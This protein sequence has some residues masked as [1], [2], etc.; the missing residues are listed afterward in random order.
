MENRVPTRISILFEEKMQSD[1]GTIHGSILLIHL[2]KG[3]LM[4]P[5]FAVLAMLALVSFA[6][7]ASGAPWYKWRN[8]IDRTILCSQLSPG[9]SW[10]KI[11]GP[12]MESQC[13][14]PGNPQ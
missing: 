12:F 13:R 1:S 2:K 3:Y 7:F 10:V 5:R 9:E 14:K 6:V 8:L 4:K 11:Q